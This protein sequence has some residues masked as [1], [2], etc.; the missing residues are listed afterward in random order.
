MRYTTATIK[1]FCEDK[2]CF[3]LIDVIAS[4]QT[5]NLKQKMNFK[6]EVNQ[7]QKWE[8]K[9]NLRRRKR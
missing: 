8:R 4:Y 5:T 1:T 6:S 9:N 2:E 3:W 7:A